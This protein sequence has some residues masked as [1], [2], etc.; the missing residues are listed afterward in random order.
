MAYFEQLTH[1]AKTYNLSGCLSIET[2]RAVE[3]ETQINY[4]TLCSSDAA[5]DTFALWSNR[6]QIVE[7]NSKTC[8]SLIYLSYRL[9]LK[10]R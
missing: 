3:L 5:A 6:F 7:M 8:A 10:Y 4:T 1:A 9:L 2:L